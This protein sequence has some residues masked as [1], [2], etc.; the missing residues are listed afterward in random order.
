M[1][2]LEL[3]AFTKAGDAYLLE[4]RAGAYIGDCFREALAYA[5]EIERPVLFSHNDR[6]FHILPTDSVD[7]WDDIEP[8][9]SINQRRP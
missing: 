7:K 2:R 5:K 6:I 8:I 3:K 9:T 1:K 4:T